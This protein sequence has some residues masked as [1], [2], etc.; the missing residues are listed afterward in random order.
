MDSARRHPVQAILLTHGHFDHTAGLGDLVREFPVPVYIHKA[1]EAM[2]SNAYLNG[3]SMI[4]AAVAFD[5]KPVLI[6]DGDVIPFGECSLTVIESPGHTRGGVLFASADGFVMTGDTLFRMSV[7][8][9][10]LPGGDYHM[11][12]TSIRN[13]I[14]PMPET[15]ILYPGHG[16]S[17]TV[18]FEKRHN[19]FLMNL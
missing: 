10:D 5:L 17:T 6:A 2:L 11:L 3:S 15:M 14:L 12:M 9:W 8:R 18:A 19:E 16:D 4:G 13:H 7:G 1:D